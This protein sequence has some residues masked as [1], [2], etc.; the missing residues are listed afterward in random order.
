MNW[1]QIGVSK[2]DYFHMLTML[3]IKNDVDTLFQLAPYIHDPYISLGMIPFLSMFCVS[4]RDYFI[5]K[6]VEINLPNLSSFS[7][8]DVRLKLKLFS[9][10]YN[11]SINN[12]STTD[13]IQDEKFKT[14]L[15][16]Q[17]LAKKNIY[18]NLGIISDSK[19]KIIFNTQQLYYLFQDKKFSHYELEGENL[20]QFGY[21]IGQIIASV[22]E[23][24]LD[25]LPAFSVDIQGFESV[26]KFKDYNT[27][28]NF[29]RFSLIENGKEITLF[30]LHILCSLNF[31]QYI[32]NVMISPDNIW[33]LRAKYIVWYYATKSVNQLADKNQIE[34][35]NALTS[36]ENDLLLNSNFRNCMMHYSFINK[37]KYLIDEK[38]LS[39]DIP[40]WGLIESCFPNMTFLSFT[41][42]IDQRIKNLS[43]N[44]ENILLID[45]SK[46]QVL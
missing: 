46:F 36:I 4:V 41:E 35:I 14:K 39:V 27:N 10:K 18:Y 20:K 2:D 3:T 21:D 42:A 40:F 19:G 28:K 30:L 31:V 13:N 1:D 12:I 17:I 8:D 25:C 32:L 22:H 9:E 23:G 6:Q 45:T 15:R 29:N 34:E 5:S 26:F 11:K 43:S 37:D 24:L 33:L 16:F 44:L 7:F 38:Y